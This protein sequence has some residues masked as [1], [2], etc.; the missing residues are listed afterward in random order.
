MNTQLTDL[1]MGEIFNRMV[2]PKV[3]SLAAMLQQSEVGLD[4]ARQQREA[5]AKQDDQAMLFQRQ[6]SDQ[7]FG[8][9]L[10]GN[11]FSQY[12]TTAEDY[13]S[14][15]IT[16]PAAK[17]AEARAM[18]REF[19]VPAP[20]PANH[21]DLISLVKEFEGYNP[22]AY[23][24]Y[25]QTSIGY[26]TRAK[27]GERSISKEEAERR[28]ADELVKSRQRVEALNKKAGYN[29]A[30]HEI[31]A[32]TSFDY[33]TG[34]LEQLTENGTR[35]RATIAAKMLEYRKAGG[36]VLPGLV[37]RREAERQVFLHG[38]KSNE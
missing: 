2:V 3:N 37:K 16:G 23:A 11:D 35:D 13:N 7:W 27:A 5:R 38:Y 32:L 1:P 24:D 26:G 15:I 19:G 9:N 18:N 4:Q 30:P 22:N 28:L 34:R 6:E 33:N 31:D 17:Q 21:K 36:K 14:P 20:G 25:K 10:P 8:E 29:L 12:A